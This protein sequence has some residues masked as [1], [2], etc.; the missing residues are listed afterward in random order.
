MPG[1]G[2]DGIDFA[3]LHPET[4]V[5]TVFEHAVPIAEFVLA[6]LLEWEIRA[7]A[8]QSSFVPEEDWPE[9]Y[10]H[11]TPHGE[12]HAKTLGFIGY[13]RIGR[14]IAAR[15]AAFGVRI[16]AVDDFG[17]PDTVA[18]LLPTDRLSDLLSRSDYVV[19]ACPLTPA[20]QG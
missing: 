20:T 13:G 8:M 17:V 2:L 3:A 14:A 12:I 10:R 1:A 4:L 6:R 11:R 7:Y 16:V 19:V 18:E 5:A 15:A 9:L